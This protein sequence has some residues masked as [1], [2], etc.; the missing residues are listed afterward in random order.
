M[1]AN[2]NRLENIVEECEKLVFIVQFVRDSCEIHGRPFRIGSST[3]S[4]LQ[5]WPR[6]SRVCRATSSTT[7]TSHWVF[8]RENPEAHPGERNLF[9][10]F[11]D[12][13]KMN[14]E[15]VVVFDGSDVPAKRGGASGRTINHQKRGLL[16]ELLRGLGIPF[17]EAPGEAEAEAEAECCSLQRLGL[18]GAVWSQDSDCMMFG[19]GLWIRDY[20]VPKEPITTKARL[21]E[22]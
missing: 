7:L 14:T 22:T 4:V 17:L 10:R 16:K 5:Y 6:S 2:I 12:I 9:T 13:L 11:C 19:C 18:V 3:V 8:D 21:K 1:S 15:V 20:R